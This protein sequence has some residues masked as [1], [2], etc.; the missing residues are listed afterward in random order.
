MKDKPRARE[1]GIAVEMVD[2]L[3]V[4][5][6][7]AADDAMDFVS[8]V[9]E[10]FGKVRA[11]L[12]GDSGNEGFFHNFQNLPSYRLFLQKGR[13][14]PLGGTWPFFAFFYSHRYL[15]DVPGPGAL[16]NQSES[17]AQSRIVRDFRNGSCT[18][19]PAREKRDLE[20][21]KT[22]RGEIDREVA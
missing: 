5:S 19:S 9:Q 22:C 11:V 12:A 18:A 6:T 14:P 4:E 17:A 2:A 10:E 8:L 7:R 1:M 20:R 16:S 21:R 13:L 15:P 3:S